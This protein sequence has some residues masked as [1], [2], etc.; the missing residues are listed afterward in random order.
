[1]TTFTLTPNN[2][3]DIPKNVAHLVV[4]EGV[5]EIPE[6]LCQKHGSLQTVVLAKSVIIIH[7][8]AFKCCRNLRSVIFPKDSQLQEIRSYAFRGCESLQSIFIPDNVTIIGEYAFAYCFKLQTAVFKNSSLQEL[9]DRAFFLCRSLQF[10]NLPDTVKEMGRSVFYSC[11]LQVISIP[12]HQ[13]QVHPEAFDY[14]DALQSISRQHGGIDC[15]K[16]RFEDLRF[17]QLC[18]DILQNNNLDEQEYFQTVQ[19]ISDPMLLQQLDVMDM[20]P[21]HILCANPMSTINMITQLYNKNRDAASIKNVNEMTP[22]HMFLVRKGIMTFKHVKSI[23]NNEV[24][25][26][27]TNMARVLVGNDQGIDF[28]NVHALISLGLDF[29]TL[30]ITILLHGKPSELQSER[31]DVTSGLFPFMSMATSSHYKLGDVYDIAM[32]NASCIKPFQQ[33]GKRKVL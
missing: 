33:L 10:I 23:Q 19:G 27:V 2:A 26:D 6:Q 24:S 17:H 30:E 4:Q 13:A 21:L 15:F 8:C 9:K 14:C 25:D 7:K 18:Y 3:Y 31:V 11:S 22:W 12:N 1:M 16:G 32:K 28:S 5:T 29:K 20:T